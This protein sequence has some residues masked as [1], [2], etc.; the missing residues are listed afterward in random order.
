M[1]LVTGNRLYG[2]VDSVP[3]LF[4]VATRF[5][6]LWYFPLVPLQSLLVIVDPDSGGRAREIAL[7]LRFKSVLAGWVRAVLFVVIAVCLIGGFAGAIEFF[8]QRRRADVEAFAV[9]LV[10]AAVLGVGYWLTHR[11]TRASEARALEL[12]ELAGIA[13]EV[14][15][16]RFPR[17]TGDHRFDPFGADFHSKKDSSD[18][19]E[20]R[21]TWLTTN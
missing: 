8:S 18:P 11:L 15:A 6:H 5:F 13:P 1:I 12:A 21:S 14:V 9:P 3:G 17:E 4:H 16:A 10:I 19:N 2:R 20:E 7:G